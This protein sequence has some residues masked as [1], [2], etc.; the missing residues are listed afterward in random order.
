VSAVEIS[1]LVVR[2]GSLTAVNGVSLR[3]EAGSITALIGSNGAGKTSI[4]EVCVGLRARQRGKVSILG[5]DPDH[6]TAQDRSGVGVMLQDGGLYPATRAR[7]WLTMLAKLTTNPIDPDELMT[8]LGIASDWPTVRRMS[9]GQVQRLKLA[10]ALIGRPRVLFLDEPT[11]GLDI[12]ARMGLHALIRALRESGTCIVLTTHDLADVEALA[13]HVYVLD[14]GR[15]VTHGSV[16]ELTDS[17]EGL[18]FLAPPRLAISSLQAVL[19]RANAVTEPDPG[20]Y[21]V[22]G[23]TSPELLATITHWCAENGILPRS[24]NVGTR[25]LS[26]IIAGFDGTGATS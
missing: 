18:R 4:I 25:G 8:Q 10:S 14:S 6:S 3:A 22:T 5:W 19:P 21:V 9:G 16:Q 17:S 26:E 13:D 20:S 1:D 15:I 24:M 23:P 11:A 12:Q 7:P 2:Y